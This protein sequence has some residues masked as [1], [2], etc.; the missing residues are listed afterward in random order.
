MTTPSPSRATAWAGTVVSAVRQRYPWAAQHTVTGPGDVDVT[1]TRL[2]PAFHG[3]FDWHSCVHMHWSGLTLLDLPGAPVESQAAEALTALLDE[4]LTAAH[5]AVEAELL[6]RRPSFE[7]PYGW[8]WG[9][10]LAAAAHTS[11][12]ARARG[13]AE[14]LTPMREV[15]VARFRAWLPGMPLPVRAGV[16]SNTAFALTLARDAACALGEEELLS[17]IDE[18]A[19][20]WFADDR[21]YPIAWE[22]DGHDFLSAA[23]SEAVLMR[24]VLGHDA[25]RDWLAG[26]LPGLAREDD[27]LFEVPATDADPTDGQL[28]HLLGLALSRAWHL[29]ELAHLLDEEAR[30]RVRDRT[31]LQI[32]RVAGAITTGDF[33]A[34]HWL[35]SFALKADLAA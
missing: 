28:A 11:P 26:F 14:A 34:T 32:E 16:H 18:R 24:R 31:R 12:R 35:V 10:Q 19:L 2:H 20:A 21:D 3:S 33:M 15:L 30:V 17:L 29:R 9:L 25:A 13:W 1:P 6:R 27:P 22:P 7:R 5:I 8:A 23:L 4:R